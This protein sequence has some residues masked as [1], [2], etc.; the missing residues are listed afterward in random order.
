MATLTDRERIT[1]LMMKGYGDRTRSNEEVQILFND[2]FRV[3]MEPISK[4]TV[5]R[6]IQRFNVSGGVKDLPRP[7][8]PVVAT[9]EEKQLNIALSINEDCHSTVRKLHQQQGFPYKKI[10]LTLK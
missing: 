2:T 1:I 9:T 5:Q 6:T 8:R 10:N 4:S 3:G 7:G